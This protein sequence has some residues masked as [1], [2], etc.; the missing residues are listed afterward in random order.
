MIHC[1]RCLPSPHMWPNN[2]QMET[3]PNLT[4]LT[5]GL[6]IQKMMDLKRLCY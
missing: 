6:K 3:F 2:L 5:I 1:D 4:L